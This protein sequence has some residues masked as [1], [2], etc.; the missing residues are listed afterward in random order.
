MRLKKSY[1]K[2]I[3][4]IFV[5]LISQISAGAVASFG[6]ANKRA[7]SGMK[8]AK[9]TTLGFAYKSDEVLVKFKA[10]T[11]TSQRRKIE[12]LA[13]QT[14]EAKK[15]GPRGRENLSLLKLKRG[16]S[17]PEALKALRSKSDVILAEPNYR[18]LLLNVPNDTYFNN[19]WGLN[20]SGQAI[21]SIAGTADADI[22]APEAWNITT[23]G[24]TIA[25]IDSGIDQSHPDL[26]SNIW[27][28]TDEIPDN[29]K[30]DD[31]NGY[32][33]DVNGYNWAGISQYY[34][35]A[36]WLLGSTTT[37]QAF[38]QSIKG[39]GRPLDHVGILLAKQGNPTGNIVVSIRSSLTGA[40]LSSFSITPAEVPTS[41]SEVYKSLSAPLT[42]TGGV[43]YYIVVSTTNN[44]INNNYWIFDNALYGPSGY[45]HDPYREGQEYGFDGSSWLGYSSDDLYFRT[46]P[47]GSARDD[48]GHGT[49]VSGIAAAIGD[50]GQG[51]AGVAWNAKIMPLKVGD[52]SGN[53]N[54]SDI[55][56]AIYYAADNGA[57]VINMSFAGPGSS[58][59]EQSA[60]NYAHSKNVVML[61]AAG[62]DYN[63]SIN[64][65]ASYNN[66]IGVGATTNQDQRA[67]FSNYN[68]SVDISAPGQDVYS[69]MP[70]Y[71]VGLN[72]YG[73]NQ[74]YDFLSGTSMASPMAAGVANLL[75]AQRPALTP[76]QIEKVLEDNADDEGAPGYD[77]EFGYGRVNAYR[78]LN[79]SAFFSSQGWPV[80]GTSAWNSANNKL[81]AG[82]F[83]HDGYQ[84]IVSFYNYPANRQVKAWVWLNDG[85]GNYLAPQVWWDSGV[86]N[87]DWAGTKLAV[88]D[89]NNDGQDD[90]VAFYGY[91]AQRQ[92]RAFVFTA[93]GSAFGPPAM[94]WDSGAG[95]WDWAGTK[96][97]VGDFNGDGSDDLAAFYGYFVQRQTRAFVFTAGASIF[98]SPSVWWDS[99]PGN[100]DWA[101]TKLSSGDFDNDN[102]DDLLAFYGYFTQHQTRAFVFKAGA[103][104]NFN[105]PSI[106]WDS[107]PGNW[108]W[109]GTK[110]QVGDFDSNSG[111]DIAALYGYGGNQ[112]RIF[113]FSANPS[114]ARFNSPG[115]WWDSGPG[116][117]SWSAT[118]FLS[119]NASGDAAL[120]ELLG[121]YDQ[122]SN[123]SSIFSFN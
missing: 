117:W 13:G 10:G 3:L 32:V 94:W 35:N 11:A 72:S 85:S 73:H 93:N 41:G 101:G 36:A 33:D 84:D 120:D 18:R 92:T 57:K 112:T 21:N 27:R 48:N 12:G 119:G 51:V 4:I 42:L 104:N 61:A 38:A 70:T 96:L 82:D 53:I 54:S 102:K 31:H 26:S 115:M 103:A 55:I 109:A 8:K 17:V 123:T 7:E 25:V 67:A 107:G 5:M 16:V 105:N 95:N 23:T 68:A 29:D 56:Q 71:L 46:N 1:F 89:F 99:G 116:N 81:A 44:D 118:T 62:N 83:N 58:A 121:F 34:L 87:W 74:I 15:F 9:T 114:A 2:F 75:S 122:G 20:N 91:A 43:T 50:N 22:D 77:N 76:A 90:L 80:S 28:N 30:D 64:Y 45:L 6:L 97:Q 14:V 106:W 52:S 113:V 49:H 39:T 108:D 37:A 88:G 79:R 69:T 24:T 40:D 47:N 110:L 111:S 60:I 100:W 78:V 98:H 86:G 63:S 66:V 65:P 19:Q 59:L